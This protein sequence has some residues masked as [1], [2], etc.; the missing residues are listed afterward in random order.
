VV[1]SRKKRAAFTTLGCK[2]N[3]YDTEGLINLFRN[4]GYRIVDF[5]DKADV[6]VI[7]TCTVTGQA[8]RKSRQAIRKAARRNPE[9]VIV[10]T[11]CYAQT[12][13]G[14]VMSV[15]GVDLVAGTA[16]RRHLVS[17]VEKVSGAKERPVIAVRDLG[18]VKVFEDLPVVDFL[19]RTR[20]TIKIQEGCDRFCA[21]CKV[22]F[23][24]GRS[25]SAP[26]EA[27]LE[28]A[29]Y[30]VSRG[31]REV[32]LTGI[33][34]GGY[35]RDLD[36]DINLAR[37]LHR[38]HTIPNLE[39]LRL[40][41]INVDDV[42]A[43]LTEALV[44]LPK[45]CRHFHIPLQSGDDDVLRAMRRRYSRHE[46]E[47]T[48]SKLRAKGDG[49]AI[50][51]DV[52]VGFPGESDEQFANSCDFVRKMAFSGLHV[53]R[54][55]R[56]KGTTA[57]SMPAQVPGQVKARRSRV[58]IELGRELALQFRRP[59]KG[60]S[61]DVLFEQWDPGKQVAEGLTDN[62]VRVQALG[63]EKDVVNRIHPVTVHDVSPDLVNGRIQTYQ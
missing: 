17:Q 39:R 26:A 49:V 52:M 30:L 40:S 46:Y 19:E 54:Y 62:Y 2:V 37:L 55:S 31:Y 44:S 29:R 8:D 27:I 7:N 14:D 4:A 6:Y 10:A 22:P 58:L 41:S 20:A 33:E 18:E 16:D 5:D 56:R 47:Q 51:T 15:E 24:R 28:R 53:F 13:P 61:V 12:N 50:T 34:I 59:L 1:G 57:A 38:V 32:V 21:Y 63:V 9:A 11:G 23:A 48:V 45:I 36:E 35:G 3:Q 60:K 42:D 25:R 43:E